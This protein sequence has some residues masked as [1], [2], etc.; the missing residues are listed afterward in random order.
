MN[1]EE[2]TIEALEARKAEIGPAIDAAESEEEVRT[3]AEEFDAIKAEMER[4]K[5]LAAEKAELR[6]KIA[7]GIEEKSEVIEEAEIPQT[8]EE[9]NTKMDNIEIRKSPEY[10]DAWVEN[11]K[12]R[13]TEEQRA[14][15]TENNAQSGSIAVPVYVEDMIHTAW[16][17]NEIVRRVRRTY[18]PGNLKVGAEV[19][20]ED[21]ILHQEGGEAINEE[22]LEIVYL[23]LVPSMIKKMV[24]VSD[25]VIGLRGQAFI[26]Y[27]FDEIEYKIVEMVGKTLVQLA[28]LKQGG[29]FVAVE[30]Y[31]GSAMTTADIV[32]AAGK[33]G[34]EATNPALIT[35]RANAAALKAAVLSAGYAYD[36][37]DGMD[38]IYV[39]SSALTVT[40]GGVTKTVDAVIA[41]LSGW[42]INLPEGD[43]VKFKFDDIT[44]AAADMVRIIG[45]LYVAMD[46][47]AP[48]KTVVIKE[49]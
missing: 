25:E 27:V 9:R 26:D 47:V 37:F 10:L 8:I 49:A 1:F 48:G 40:A 20:S 3:L 39:D 41:D 44:E 31:T 45:R 36:P 24:R 12:G 16:E 5:S 6:E 46:I 38:V 23:N 33:L 43:T 14:L 11:L 15:L 19:G 2:M 21:A 17:K 13:A 35:T 28:I 32:N 29:D 4:R 22:Q 18:F 7:S 42:Q 34:G 30:S